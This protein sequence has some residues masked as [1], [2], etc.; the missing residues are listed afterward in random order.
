[1]RTILKTTFLAAWVLVFFQTLPEPGSRPSQSAWAGVDAKAK[2][3]ASYGKLPLAFEDLKA[4][5]QGKMRFVSRG[6]G[7]AIW[8]GGAEIGLSLKNG[9]KRDLI[10]MELKGADAAAR[11]LCLEKLPG[12]S[13]YL[14]GDDPGRWS[15]DVPR[16]ARARFEG[17][18]PGIDVEYYGNQ[19]R[20]EYDILVKPGA[21]PGAIL[22]EVRGAKKVR[23]DGQGDLVL[24]AE[25]G[26]VLFKKPACYQ[27][28]GFGSRREV[29]GR[30]TLKDGNKVGFELAAYDR[31]KEL[32]IDPVLAYST[33][34]GGSGWDWVSD[35][36]VD[37]NGC[38]YVTGFT[39]S[40]DFPTVN[41]AQGTYGGGQYDVFVAK[42]NATG[43]ALVYCTFLGGN[44]MDLGNGIA[45]DLSG[46]AYVTGQT[47]SANFPRN[48]AFQNSLRGLSDM[49]VAKLNA[50][51]NGLVYST[52]LGGAPTKTGGKSRLT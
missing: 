43:G 41:A 49:F 51:G 15:L 26:D 3:R 12:K 40:T 5:P 48:N 20:L 35:I 46:C 24:S 31:E 7:R 23:L 38:A 10:S 13:N 29:E 6:S 44:D 18:Y 14:I 25:G 34:L 45:V 4:R 28:Q 36:A 1:M 8:L 27:S 32:V 39:D 37:L 30:Y 50:A 22:W 16:Y 19:D 33:Y 9:P 42:L 17:V 11:A 52:F 21:D 2:V 47:Y